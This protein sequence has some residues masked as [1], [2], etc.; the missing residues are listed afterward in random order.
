MKYN[1]TKY[2]NIYYYETAKGKRYYVRRSFF[3]RG[4]KREKSKSGF[5]TLPQARAALVELEQQIQDLELGINTNLTLDQ[6]WD[7][8]SEK[9]LSTGRWNDTSY[10]LNDNLYKNHIKTKF[11]S[12]LLKNLDRNEYELFI[13]EKLQNHTRYTVQTLNSSFMA[14]LNDAVKNGN[15]L[16]NRLKGVFIGQSDI[17]ATNKKVTLKEFKTWIAKAEEIMP[18][19]FYALTYLTIFGLRR[20]EVFGLRPMDVT[21]NDNGR[22][23]LHLRDSRSNQ[24]LKGKGGLKTKDSERYVCLDDIGTDLIYYLIAEASKIKRKLGIIKDQRKDYITLNE[25]GGLINP[26]QLNRNFNLVN[27]A[28]GLHVTPHMMR[29]FFTTQSIIAGVPLEQLSQALGHTK[30]YMTDRYNQVEDE[31]AEATTDLFL[32]HIR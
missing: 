16:S 11:G 2:P 22:A 21:Q 5:T 10:Y 31:L 8:Y 20:G 13:A 32:S 25:K 28:T 19:Q 17:P 12:T 29:H 9:R 7:I 30:V 3:F 23:I 14:L 27:E 24:T 15:L 4:K 18:K 6:Y 1:K 26:N